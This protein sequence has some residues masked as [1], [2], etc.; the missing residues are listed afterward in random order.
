MKNLLPDYIERV[1]VTGGAG[2]IGLNAVRYLLKN[3][4][5]KIF[6]IDKLGYASDFSGIEEILKN[7][8]V[9]AEERYE[10]NKLNLNNLKLLEEYI[11]KSKPNLILHFAAETQVD[12]S[13]DNP[14]EFVHSN[15]IGTYNLLEASRKYFYKLSNEQK[16][17]FRLHHI[18]TDEVFG[19]LGKTGKFS[20]NTP[21]SPRS[22]Y[23]ASK[24]ASDHF[25]NAWFH[26]YGVPITLSNS[27]NNYGPWQFPEKLIPLV[28]LKA[29][30]GQKIP[31]YGDGSNIR[32]WL[33]VSDHI[34]A[35]INIA[36]RSDPGVNYCIG[37][38]NEKTNKDVVET[39]CSILDNIYPSKVSY[40]NLIELVDDR[41]GHDFRYSIDT[42]KISENLNW[43]PK[44]G[45][46]E[47]ILKTVKWYINNI[48]WCKKI[49]NKSI[50]KLERLGKI[51][52]LI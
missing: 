19:S 20:E 31:L 44:Y 10:F 41:P 50:Y 30:S 26:T 2:F 29:L 3:S 1:L 17:F 47:G 51:K 37:G 18:S 25:V 14:D 8:G 12:R 46:N 27:S 6:N 52:P 7:I 24:A 39:I 36:T 28:I 48:N 42:T 5:V 21:Y 32:D 9:E 43:E 15:V 16:Q 23:S 4:K 33:F 13:I 35:V 40:S 34:N 11:E 22:P 45:F 38:L 49:Q